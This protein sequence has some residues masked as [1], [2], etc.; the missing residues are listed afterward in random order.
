MKPIETIYAD[1]YKGT[2]VL[3]EQYSRKDDGAKIMALSTTFWIQFLGV[4]FGSAMMYFTFVKYKRRELNS[5]EFLSLVL[6]LDFAHHH[7][8]S[9]FRPGFY[10]P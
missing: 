1:R 5:M 4:T 6:L 3:T 7:R 2:T 10:H 9:P 8:L